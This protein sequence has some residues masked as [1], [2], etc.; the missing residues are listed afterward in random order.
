[1]HGYDGEVCMHVILVWVRY[2]ARGFYMHGCVKLR[3]DRK[4]EGLS[5]MRGVW[6]CNVGRCRTNLNDNNIMVLEP[7]GA[8]L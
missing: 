5:Y 8:V 4:V 6:Q 7:S 2:V 3:G 1:M